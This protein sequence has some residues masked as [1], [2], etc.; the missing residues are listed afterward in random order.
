MR[1]YRI[2]ASIIAY[3]FAVTSLA[4]PVTVSLPPDAIFAPRPKYP[5]EALVRRVAGSGIFLLR[6]HIP[7]GRVKHVIVGYTTGNQMLDDDAVQ[8]LLQWRFKP[9]AVPYRKISSVRLSPP[10][11][12][13]ETLIKVPVTFIPKA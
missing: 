5:V 2:F 13:E 1:T 10:Q 9:G 3:T 6:V 12:E 8:A 11:T 4:A 7:T